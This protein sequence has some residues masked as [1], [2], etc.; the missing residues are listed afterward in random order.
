[1]FFLS[2]KVIYFLSKIKSVG[3]IKVMCVSS[4]AYT[5]VFNIILAQYKVLRDK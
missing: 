5:G 2:E 3:N 1:M 4:L